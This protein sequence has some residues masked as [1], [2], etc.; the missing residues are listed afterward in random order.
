MFEFLKLLN[1]HVY[2]YNFS[3]TNPDKYRMSGKIYSYRVNRQ[4]RHA[5]GKQMEKT[6]DLGGKR[7]KGALP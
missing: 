2:I 5:I 6:S 4:G 7:K 3:A 1:Q